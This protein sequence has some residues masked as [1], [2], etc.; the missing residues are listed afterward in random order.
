MPHACTNRSA[1]RTTYGSTSGSPGCGSFFS[2]E[3]G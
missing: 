3:S 1:N 2:G